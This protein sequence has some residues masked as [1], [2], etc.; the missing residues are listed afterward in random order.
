VYCEDPYGDEVESPF[1]LV[2][3]GALVPRNVAQH[4]VPLTI[5]WP[6]QESSQYRHRGGG[7][8]RWEEQEKDFGDEDEDKR[9]T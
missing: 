7:R 9:G 4:H 5:E 1:G 8:D 2:F 3:P 6:S